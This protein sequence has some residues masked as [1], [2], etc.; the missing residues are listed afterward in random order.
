MKKNPVDKSDEGGGGGR[1]VSFQLPANNPDQ[2][3]PHAHSR[4]YKMAAKGPASK[5]P[6]CGTMLKYTFD[7][8][9]SFSGTGNGG[10]MAMSCCMRHI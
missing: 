9:P 5:T 4:R 10:R 7:S 1:P 8:A 3:T 2:P 6:R